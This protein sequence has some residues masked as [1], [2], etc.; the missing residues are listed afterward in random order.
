VVEVASQLGHAP[1][2]TLSTYAHVMADVDEEDRRPADE[3]ISEA[4]LNQRRV[5]ENEQIE[6]GARSNV[7][8]LFADGPLPKRF[9]S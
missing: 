4:R 8:R 2:M 9:A 7:R 1:T 6:E 3:L 5:L